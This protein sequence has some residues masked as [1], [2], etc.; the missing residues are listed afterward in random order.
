MRVEESHRLIR[1]RK[2]VGRKEGPGSKVGKQV[3]GG[4]MPQK[5]CVQ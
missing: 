1:E 4:R 5:G 3:S 2:P